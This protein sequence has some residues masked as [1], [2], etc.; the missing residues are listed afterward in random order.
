MAIEKPLAPIDIGPRPI[1]PTDEQKVEVEVVNPEAVSIET[2]D[3]GMIIDF[4]KEEDNQTSEFDSNLAEFIE[5]SD[6]E[7]LA[8]ELLSSFESDKQSR[9]EWAKSYVK[10]LDL[11]G[12]KIE[13]RQQPWAGSSGVFH[14][15]LTE[16]I[17]RF[18]AQAMGEIFPAQGPVRTKTVGKITQEKTEQAKRVENEMNYLLTE[19][20]TEYR[21]ETEQMLFKLP[22]AGSAFKKVYYD[23]LLERPCAMFVPAE[24]FVVSY[25]VT[26]LM[27]CERYT[28]VMKKTQNEVAKLQDNGFYRDVDLPEPEAEYTDIQEKYDD[29]D[30]E[31]AVLEDDDRHTLLEMHADI[32]LPEPFEEEDG[33]A[34]PHVITIE[35]SSRTILSIRRNYYEDDEKKRKRQFFVHYRYLPGLGFYGTGLIHLIG[36]LAKSA[37]SI[38]R[39]LIDAGTLSNLPAGLKARGLRIKGD[40]SPL[41]PGEF[42]DV[43]VPGGAI[44]DAIT[45]IP[46]KEPSSVLYQLLQ[47]IVDEGRRIGSVADIQVGDINAQ[48]PVGTT[49]ALME[50][51]MK[52]MSG[53]QARLH[54][55]LK[56]ELRLLSHIVKDYMGPEYVYEMEGEFSR[57]KDFDDRVDVI[58]VSDP[59]AATMSQRIMQYQSALQLS[60][61]APQ[62]YDM[63]KLHRQ[64]LEVLGIDQAKDII[65][66]PDDIKPSDPVTENMAM[67]KQEPVKAFKYQDHEA[68]I[69]V[70][71]AAIEDPKLREIVGQSPFAAAIQAAM[72][73]HITEH[74]A[75]QYR[76]EI[77]ERL[78]VPMPD[79]DKPLPEDVEE[80]LSRITAEAAGKL[81][82]KNTQEAQQM[83]QQKL[84]K[85]PLTQIQRKELEIKEKELQHK[86]DLDNAKLE[87]EKMKADNNEDI[88]MERIKSEN[89]REGAR[90]AVEVAKEKNKA[91]KDGTKLAI[92]LNE[93]LKDG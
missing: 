67:L 52:V 55:A 54:A 35:K 49:L 33:I 85:D 79:E 61:Q 65:K 38:L 22:L 47:N 31:S 89:K 30:G 39:Q 28:H 21:D 43:D 12:M 42:R 56:K 66:L 44:R 88:Q 19:E 81:L 70:H 62:L 73:A 48:A 37:T 2:E 3:G 64:M 41:M 27:T 74:V 50:R 86:I 92:E 75:F 63:G 1:E 4:G 84:E 26:D 46:Y 10:G 9:G 68:H 8:S 58:P 87:L 51:S 24:D 90:L 23:P 36:G 13:E 80:E 32:E 34:R 25:G 16:S 78:G 83:E 14:P 72:T 69:Q 11:L 6:L 45:F 17:V 93:S 15:V 91:T 20:M 29:L 18:Q 7:K 53:V 5:E 71:R 77:E 76:K 60:Q 59:N 40:D 82:T 57:T